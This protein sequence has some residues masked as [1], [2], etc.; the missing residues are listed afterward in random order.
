MVEAAETPVATDTP[1]SSLTIASDLSLADLQSALA[2]GWQ[3]FP[4]YPHFGL[5]LGA[6]YLAAGLLIWA[7]L[8]A[9][10]RAA[11]LVPAAAG[12]PL[13]APFLAVG[14]HE[15]SRRRELGLPVRWK[16][17]L[18]ALRG[19]GDEQ[20]LSMGVIVLVDREVDFLTAIITSIATMRSNPIVMISWAG[21]I[22]VILAVAMRPLFPGLLVALPVLAHATWHLYRRAIRQC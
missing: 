20:V 10:G 7:V 13:I 18:G 19:R 5:F 8:S 21:F 6:I 11:W 9:E 17:V 16:A 1:E 3:D 12:F 22:A 4:A 2:K 15:V 14:L